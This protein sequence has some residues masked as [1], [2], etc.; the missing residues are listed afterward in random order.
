MHICFDKFASLNLHSLMRH[1]GCIVVPSRVDIL[2]LLNLTNYC[3]L[4]IKCPSCS[5][6]IIWSLY[7]FIFHNFQCKS[8]WW[9]KLVKI[10][11]DFWEQSTLCVQIVRITGLICLEI[12]SIIEKTTTLIEW[13]NHNNNWGNNHYYCENN[14]Y[15]FGNNFYNNY[16]LGNTHY[17]WV[18]ERGNV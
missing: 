14:R 1:Q 3:Y 2:L 8:I 6:I 12:I 11:F 7:T 15:Y 18:I 17:N 4:L 9:E 13:S 5:R 16:F 10:R